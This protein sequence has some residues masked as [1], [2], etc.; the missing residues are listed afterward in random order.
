MNKLTWRERMACGI[1]TNLKY[2]K[3]D[4]FYKCRQNDAILTVAKLLLRRDPIKFAIE[5]LE[6]DKEEACNV[7][8]T[9][10]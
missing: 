10:L 6:L 2:N 8:L 7:G 3:E 5:L 9:N 4:K 1:M